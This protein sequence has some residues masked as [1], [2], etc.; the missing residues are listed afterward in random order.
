MRDKALLLIPFLIIFGCLGCAKNI[1]SVANKAFIMVANVA[2][3]TQSM[4]VYFNG[5]NLTPTAALDFGSFS[6][7]Q[8][9]P[10]LT[11]ISG[12]HNIT[13]GPDITTHYI[14]GNVNLE[15][16][17][18]YSLFIYDTLQAGNLKSLILFD[19]LNPLDTIYS[20][21]RFMNFCPDTVIFS[22][23]LTNAVDTIPLANAPYVGS[24]PDPNNYSPFRLIPYGI[25]NLA[26]SVDSVVIFNDSLNFSSGKN[27][28]LYSRG[29]ING[30]GSDTLAVGKI[31][32]N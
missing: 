21:V 24:S 18:F 11:A 2:P 8:G 29:F 30:S 26:I 31:Q 19:H 16:N 14:N 5:E 23:L 32:L 7:S 6:G 13:L 9:S 28:S 12:T 10:Y 1:D 27:Y 25:Y 17:A 22:L 15:Q 3:N 20:A 4:N